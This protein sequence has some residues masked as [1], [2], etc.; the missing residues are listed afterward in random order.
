MSITFNKYEDATSVVHKTAGGTSTNRYVSNAWA[1]GDAFADTDTAG[2][3]I[4]FNLTKYNNLESITRCGLKINVSTA[5]TAT[6]ATFLWE[7]KQSSGAGTWASLEALPSFVDNTNH[8]QTT[9]QNTVEFDPQE[10]SGTWWDNEIRLRLVTVSGLTDGGAFNTSN[11]P[12]SKHYCIVVDSEASAVTTDTIYDAMVSGGWYNM[13]SSKQQTYSKAFEVLCDLEFKSSTYKIASELVHKT[14]PSALGRNRPRIDLDSSSTFQMGELDADGYGYDSGAYIQSTPQG[15]Y[16]HFNCLGTIKIYGSIF[17]SANGLM[18][19]DF[20]NNSNNDC[21]DS[22]FEGLWRLTV[23]REANADFPFR[24]CFFRLYQS[25][26][27]SEGVVIANKNYTYNVYEPYVFESGFYAYLGTLYVYNQRGVKPKLQMNIGD[28]YYD[29]NPEWTGEPSVSRR[30]GDG[31]YY[32]QVS[33]D[34]NVVDDT[35]TAISGATVVLKDKDNNTVFSTTTDANGDI[36]Q[37]WVTYLSNTQAGG[38]ELTMSPFTL[39]ITKT[40]YDTYTRTLTIARTYSSGAVVATQPPPFR[41]M[42]MMCATSSGGG[43]SSGY[44]T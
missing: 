5:M 9:G 16:H 23:N 20:G 15:R 1:S 8:L 28:H 4:V 18:A 33:F 41:L 29:R 14:L 13:I 36:T 25:S 11:K 42:A 19:V 6:S 7:Y 34:V 43:I 44:I 2:A 21:V 40:G 30:L 32:A 24:R 38:G 10:M 26:S 39:T 17:K 3:V 37:Q 22:R 12:Q 35:N 27:L 31:G